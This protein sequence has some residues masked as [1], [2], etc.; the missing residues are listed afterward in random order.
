MRDFDRV[1]FFA[2]SFWTSRTWFCLVVVFSL[3]LLSGERSAL[4]QL[5]K[6]KV[7][8][9]GKQPPPAKD[10]LI[11]N[12]NLPDG[13]QPPPE[14]MAIMDLD[15][16]LAT[17][18]ELDKLRKAYVNRFFKVKN[19]ADLSDDGRKVI[20]GSIRYKLAYMTLKENPDKKEKE[21]QILQLPALHKR[22]IED[23][24]NV[25]QAAGNKAAVAAMVKFIGDEVVRQIQPLLI[26]N[27]YVRL[28]AVMILG[29]MDYAPAFAPL[30]QVIQAKDIHDDPIEGQ[31]EAIKI[32]AAMG[33]IRILT[34]AFTNPPPTVKDRTA[35][36]NAVVNELVRP[37]SHWW[38]QVRLIEV[39]RHCDITGVDAVNNNKPFVVDAL[40][41]VIKDAE[42]SW[43]VRAKACYAIGRVPLPPSIKPDDV[44]QA[45]A[46]FALEMA[47]A[48]AAK[49]NNLAWR[50]CFWDLYLAFHPYDT[51]K[52]KDLDA[53]AKLPG[54][55]LARIK[56]AAQPAYNLIYPLVNDVLNDKAPDPGNRQKLETFLQK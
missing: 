44:V 46:S 34:P 4:A 43:I 25:G 27:F 47:K 41:S 32:A 28:H 53:E 37:K 26:N 7:P 3:S 16:P 11:I 31:P 39:L 15:Q 5:P 12:P 6:G 54:G 8:P 23:L 24:Q 17:K 50:S 9:G 45:V 29:E 48:A 1:T 49:P 21:S 42:R 22:F 51:T 52:E 40:L 10:D 33:L 30:I 2:S 18:D 38:Y 20:S 36:A 14:R 19:E 35:I 56:A 55:L 13:F